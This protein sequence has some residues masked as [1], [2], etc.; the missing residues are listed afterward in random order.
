MTRATPHRLRDDP[1]PRRPADK[2]RF[3][4]VEGRQFLA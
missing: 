2:P 3:A 1:T 4:I